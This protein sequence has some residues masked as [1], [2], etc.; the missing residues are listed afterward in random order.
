MEGPLAGGRFCPRSRAY[1][2]PVL[3]RVTLAKAVW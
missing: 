2:W 1:V 3:G